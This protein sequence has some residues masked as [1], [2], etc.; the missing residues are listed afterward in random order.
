M[1]YPERNN[2]RSMQTQLQTTQPKETAVRT[3]QKSVLNQGRLLLSRN[4]HAHLFNS[5]C[6]GMETDNSHHPRMLKQLWALVSCSV[7]QLNPAGILT[8]E[9]REKPTEREHSETLNVNH[10]TLYP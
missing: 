3:T 9:T 1:P 2:Q 8:C 10:E 5:L 7:S 4:T 6:P